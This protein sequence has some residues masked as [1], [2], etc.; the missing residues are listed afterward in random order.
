MIPLKPPHFKLNTT[1]STLKEVVPEQARRLF[2]VKNTIHIMP[3]VS[4]QTES[5][6]TASG[7]KFIAIPIQYS[8]CMG[9]IFQYENP[10]PN[11]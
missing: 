2:T 7:D 9:R 6:A 11:P 1:L 10:P 5:A 4:G 3:M 8:K